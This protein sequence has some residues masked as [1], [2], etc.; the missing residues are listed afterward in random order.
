MRIPSI[1]QSFPC[2][3]SR[4]SQALAEMRAMCDRS[5]GSERQS[6]AKRAHP[7]VLHKPVRVACGRHG[8]LCFVRLIFHVA[9][10]DDRD[11]VVNPGVRLVAKRLRVAAARPPA[12]A[13]PRPCISCVCAYASSSCCVKACVSVARA[14]SV[15]ACVRACVRAVSASA[16]HAQLGLRRGLLRSV[17]ADL[18]HARERWLATKE[19]ARAQHRQNSV[20]CGPL[21]GWR[22]SEPRAS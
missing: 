20:R 6:E 19:R 10:A 5:T 9:V 12:L 18:A 1:P 8:R 21:E 2:M 22:E 4:A 3:T 7:R 13:I 16:R 11:G 14:V 15:R 17:P